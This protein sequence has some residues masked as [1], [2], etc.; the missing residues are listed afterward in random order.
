MDLQ[1]KGKKALVTGSTAGIGFAT[2]R[3]LAAE[4]ASVMIN[5]RG[6]ARV[7]AA[8]REMRKLH[9]SANV[10]GAQSDVSNSKGCAKLIR[11]RAK[12]IY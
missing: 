5:G 6:Q 4:G 11:P 12:S 3:A 9:P 10:S 2:A 7:D 1:L 8:I